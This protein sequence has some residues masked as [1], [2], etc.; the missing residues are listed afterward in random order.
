MFFAFWFGRRA[1][2]KG[3][4]CGRAELGVGLTKG[5]EMQHD[6][7]SNTEEK[8]ELERR[9]RTSELEGDLV[10]AELCGGERVELEGRRRTARD[11]YEMG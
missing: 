5:Q 10:A 4:A 2:K 9:L 7:L 8:M 11:L 3:K 1:P 6:E